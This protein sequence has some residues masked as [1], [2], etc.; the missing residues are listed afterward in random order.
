[1]LDRLGEPYISR[2]KKGMGLG[3]FISK[4]L[5]E[6]MKGSISFKNSINNYAIVEIKL[7]KTILI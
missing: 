2:N 1:V 4:N 6:N 3:I 7:D 5:I